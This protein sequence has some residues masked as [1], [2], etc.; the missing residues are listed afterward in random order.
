MFVKEPAWHGLGTV[1]DEP[2]TVSEAIVEAGLDWTVKKEPLF[3]KEGVGTPMLREVPDHFGLVR[4]SDKRVLGVT[5]ERYRPLQNVEAFEFFNP[6]LDKGVATLDTAG[7]LQ[8]GKIVWVMAKLNGFEADVVKDDP[9]EARLLLS[10]PHTGN[11][12]VKVLF[13]PT[14]V[15]CWNTLRAAEEGTKN[16]VKI[17]HSKNVLNSLTAVQEAVDVANSTFAFTLDHYRAMARKDISVDGLKNY[18]RKVLEVPDEVPDMPRAWEGI[19]AAF[20]AGPGSDIPG[21]GGTVWNAYNSVTH[22]IDH[23]RGRDAESR[24]NASW[25]QPGVGN[26]LRRRAHDEAMEIVGN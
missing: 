13:T 18:V 12:A 26:A 5:G 16:L 17:V 23:Q 20:E 3:T 11:G 15:V 19:E 4:S 24:L 1:L 7:S 14:R 8:G 9:V 10:N 6:F 25:F 21:V 2:P 22:W